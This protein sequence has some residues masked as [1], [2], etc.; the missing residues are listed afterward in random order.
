[1]AQQD[2]KQIVRQWKREIEDEIRRLAAARRDDGP[3]RAVVW[4]ALW[5]VWIGVLF[6][7][8]GVLHPLK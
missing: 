8:L 4:T 2:S 1:L 3:W 5:F 7:M 6:G